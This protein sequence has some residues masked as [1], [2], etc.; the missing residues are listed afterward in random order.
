MA[1]I[2]PNATVEELAISRGIADSQ[3]LRHLYHDPA[4][5]QN[6]LPEMGQYGALISKIEQIRVEALGSRNFEGVAQNLKAKLFDCLQ[7]ED[8]SNSAWKEKNN[9]AKILELVLRQ[10]L[11][12]QP[13]PQTIGKIIN[14][15]R[16]VLEKKIKQH[17]PILSATLDDQSAFLRHVLDMLNSIFKTNSDEPD[18]KVEENQFQKKEKK[19]EKGQ[20]NQS[21]SKEENEKSD[22][23][24][25]MKSG[26][27]GKLS[28]SST[29]TRKTLSLRHIEQFF[30]PGEQKSLSQSYTVF[31][32][33]FDRIVSAS[34]LC[35]PMELVQLR[36]TLDQKL[37]RFRGIAMRAA[38]NLQRKL[39][40]RQNSLWRL[41][42][43][44]GYLDNQKLSQIIVHPLVPLSY[45][46]E[47]EIN[48]K[49][50]IVTLLLDNSGSMR[51]RPIIIAAICADIIAY[52]L[53][54]CGVKVEVLGFT[55][56]AWNG[57]KAQQQW[58]EEGKT[59]NPGRL[60][61]ILHV[62]YKSANMPW[63]RARRNLGLMLKEGLLKE[64][65]DGEALLWALQ[66]LSLCSEKRR[67]LM[68][69]S[70]GAPVDDATLSANS[71][72]YLEQH[73]RQV[74]KEIE[75]RTSVEL[76]AIGIGH[77]V[78]AY[79]NRSLTIVR[80][81]ELANAMV[82]QLGKLFFKNDDV[83]Q[84]NWQQHSG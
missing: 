28:L 64:N 31:T 39:L 37:T 20:T 3:A 32:T 36:A 15:Q 9:Q 45:K 61:E 16:L 22:S 81:E 1:D 54:K 6:F 56:G 57:G 70:D 51:G 67:I 69:I 17:L 73:L 82:D 77:D 58:A 83:R 59:K 7:A 42:M 71:S 33:K 72:G 44:E 84:K 79:Y 11:A 63:V 76:V 43:E 62:V 34:D 80:I 2:K 46:K 48:L 27:T 30:K 4:T 26:K 10:H 47:Q 66:R 19:A 50:T 38:K 53:E 8:F 35:S 78:K 55:T 52:I 60:N 41:N 12:R 65:I 75:R 68:V 49:D 23:P 74:I 18:S 24:Q 29:S 25:C 40:A 5:Y 14:K 13:V 21:G